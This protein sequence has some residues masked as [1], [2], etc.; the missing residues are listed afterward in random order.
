M[1]TVISVLL[2]LNCPEHWTH[3]AEISASRQLLLPRTTEAA[4]KNV[5]QDSVC[6]HARACVRAW[7]GVCV[8]VNACCPQTA[9]LDNCVVRKY[10]REGL[11]FFPK[12]NLT[13]LGQ[14]T[15]TPGS[16]G[17]KHTRECVR[18]CACV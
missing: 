9:S 4:L 14:I 7:V 17:S 2:P 8:S 3:G 1:W 18:A 15:K 12:S 5:S 13:H 11:L 16:P 6:A 10:S